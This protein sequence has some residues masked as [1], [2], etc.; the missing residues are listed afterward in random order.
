MAAQGVDRQVLS[1]WADIFG[2]GQP[3]EQNRK[4][5]RFLNE[6]L[7]RMCLSH[8]KQFSM[9]ASLPLTNATDAAAELEYAVRQLGAVGAVVSANVENVNLGELD[10]EALWT[11]VVELDVGVFVHPV[12]TEP[13]PRVAKFALTQ[14]A[15]YTFDTTLCVGSLIF[16][17]VLDRFPDLRLLLSHGGGT[18]PCLTGRFDCM[19]V[20]MDKAAQQDVAMHPRSA[21]MKRFYYDTIV[22]DPAILKWLSERVSVSRVVL[23][24]DYS[25]PPADMDPLRTIG[26]AGFSDA[27]RRAIEETNARSL[28]PALP[29]FQF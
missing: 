8:D 11:T 21:Y 27:D 25:F 9:L 14:I 28:F 18:F 10:L 22:H 2:Y 7:A 16:G 26:D 17:G 24:T 15:Q 13:S 12:Q 20:L 29:A 5:H 1:M 4:W 3:P 6:H 23:G 19:H